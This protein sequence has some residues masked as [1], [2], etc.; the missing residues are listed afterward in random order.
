MISGACFNL[1][2]SLNIVIRINYGGDIKQTKYI[3]SIIEE[4]KYSYENQLINKQNIFTLRF[5]EMTGK[6]ATN[7]DVNSFRWQNH[8]C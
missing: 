7:C 2:L 8:S 6:Q 1:V 5:R 3:Y 4:W